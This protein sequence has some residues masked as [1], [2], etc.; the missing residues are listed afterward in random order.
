MRRVFFCLCA[1]ASC[2]ALST[3]VE[4][5]GPDPA[6]FPL[7]VHI[8]KFA[9]QPRQSKEAKK[10]SDDLDYVDGQ[11][12]ADL[13]EGGLPTGFQFT[14]SCIEDVRE[15]GGYGTFPA[16][17]KKKGKTLVVLVPEAGKSWNMEACELHVE[18]RPGV[19]YYLRGDELSAEGSAVFKE[20]MDKHQYDP[21]NGK[22][23]PIP[24]DPG[25]MGM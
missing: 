18:M 4:A 13:F 17:W 7:R 25:P 9:S 6:D 24:P 20:W 11:G 3:A 5:G 12:V 19:A 21:E 22:D 2:V 15:S 1:I 14:Y 10:M 23:E 8:F 16:R